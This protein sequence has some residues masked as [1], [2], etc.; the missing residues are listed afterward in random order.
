[1]KLLIAIPAL[2]EEESID[3][4]IRRSIDARE[5]ICANS[6]VTE[7]EITV[8]SDGST[9]RTVERAR[10]YTSSINL[11]VF[12]KNRGYG[13]AIKEAWRQSDAEFLGFLDADGTCEPK[14]FAILCETAVAQNADVVLGCRLN[15]NSQMPLIRRIGNLIFASILSVFSSSR[16]RDTASGMRVVRRSS[17]D[18]LYP[19]PDG[20]HFT[21]AMSARAMLSE[22]TRIREVDMPYH[23]RSGESKLRVARDGVRFLRVI[24]EAAFLYRPSRPLGLLAIIFALFATVMMWSPI[25]YYLRNRSV[26]EWMIYRFLISDLLGI[27]A[28]LCFC[29]SYLTGRMT[30]IA[31]TEESGSLRSRLT[32]WFFQTRWF[33][34]VPIGLSLVGASLVISS[35]LERLTTGMTYEHWSKYV[36][37]SFCFASAIVLSVTRV[38]DYVLNL[39]GDRLEYL[40]MRTLGTSFIQSHT[41]VSAPSELET[42]ESAGTVV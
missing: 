37:M 14:F 2:N 6:P 21:P 34:S 26:A 39:V 19:L 1:M 11:I 29:A 33:W 20:L 35:L 15:P 22:C 25:L 28:C 18:L 23:E 32:R 30:S 40:R 42:S 3:S 7:V 9:D 16:V 41:R 8:V 12:P 38:I 5:F 10:R 31:L 27:T 4:I 36:V 24:L 17:L 13:A